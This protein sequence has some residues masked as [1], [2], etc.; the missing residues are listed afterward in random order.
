MKAGG[1][2]KALLPVFLMWAIQFNIFISNQ[3][4]MEFV[5]ETDESNVA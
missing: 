2:Q 5:I 4:Y 1:K 3:Y